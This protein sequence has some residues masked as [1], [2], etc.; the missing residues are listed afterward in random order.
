MSPNSQH[1][2][3]CT[4]P[5]QERHV[6]RCLLCTLSTLVRRTQYQNNL[7]DIFLFFSSRGSALIDFSTDKVSVATEASPR[8]HWVV[9]A[10]GLLMGIAFAAIL[11]FGVLWPAVGKVMICSHEV[12]VFDKS[13]EVYIGSENWLRLTL[14]LFWKLCCRYFLANGGFL[15]IWRHKL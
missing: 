6:A 9:P 14:A 12:C 4:T 7:Y 8:P 10:H 11:P 13:D 5:S 1:A 15:S 2:L 3:L